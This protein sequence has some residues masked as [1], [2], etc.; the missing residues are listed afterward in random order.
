MSSPSL[1]VEVCLPFR[2]VATRY[3]FQAPDPPGGPGAAGEGPLGKRIYRPQPHHGRRSGAYRDRTGDLR[4]ASACSAPRRHSGSLVRYV[5][6]E[7]SAARDLVPSPRHRHDFET[8]ALTEE[9]DLPFVSPAR[10]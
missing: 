6:V 8:A 9:P 3:R 5:A 2:L 1:T 4:L 10:D 7:P